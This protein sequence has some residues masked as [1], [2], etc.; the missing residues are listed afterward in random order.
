[1]P[2][3]STAFALIS[4]RKKEESDASEEKKEEAEMSDG[5]ER[6]ATRRCKEPKLLGT[7]GLL[8]K[9]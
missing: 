7:R 1:M 8:V 2:L 4:E 3:F 9:V 6:G 5:G